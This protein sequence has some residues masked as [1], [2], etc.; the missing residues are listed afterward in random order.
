MKPLIIPREYSAFADPELISAVRYH[1]TGRA[2]MTLTEALLYLADYIEEGRKFE[3]CVALRRAFLDA[4][5][6]AMSPALRRAHLR[7]VLLLSFDN[8]LS[9]LQASGGSV[10]LDTLAAREDIQNRSEF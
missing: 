2:D 6:A 5:P 8:T 9:D 7:N 4:D 3:D 10:C 1:T